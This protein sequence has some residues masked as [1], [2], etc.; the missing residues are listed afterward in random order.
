[1]YRSVDPHTHLRRSCCLRARGARATS[2]VSTPCPR[3]IVSEWMYCTYGIRKEIL[4]NIHYFHII[5]TRLGLKFH[6]VYQK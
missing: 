3:R 6:V 4:L 5:A 2:R 1:M